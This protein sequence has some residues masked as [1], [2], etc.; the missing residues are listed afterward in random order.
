VHQRTEVQRLSRRNALRVIHGPVAIGALLALTPNPAAADDDALTAVVGSWLIRSGPPDKPLA[1]TSLITYT[2]QGTCI[3]TTVSHPMRSPAM[4]VWTPLGGQ[5]FAVTFDAFAFD[6]NGH[7]TN[8]SQV[9][10]QSVLDD[11]LDSYKGS[12][13]TY[14]L[15]DDGSAVRLTNSG[16]VSASPIQL[17]RLESHD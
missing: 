14:A 2:A 3:Q 17:A 4:G 5:E 11:G 15:D 16:L 8:V 7:F 13:Q 6:P 10:V 12:F 1:I 9:R